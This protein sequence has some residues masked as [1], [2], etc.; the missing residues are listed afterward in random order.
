MV[1]YILRDHFSGTFT[2][3][4]AT[5]K[6]LIPLSDFLHYAW[7]ENEGEEKFIWGMPDFIFIPQMIATENL[8]S[9]LNTLNV[10]PLNPPSGFASGIRVIRDIENDLRFFMRETVD[11]SL[12]G[13]NKLRFVVLFW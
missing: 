4:I 10:K 11:Y 5:T 8:L 9:V 12:E 1:Y 6:R 3:R 7:S 2:L 13:L